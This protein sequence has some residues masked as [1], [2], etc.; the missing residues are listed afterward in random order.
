MLP[1]DVLDRWVAGTAT[2]EDKAL[3]AASTARSSVAA[4]L[5]QAVGG[6]ESYSW[7]GSDVVRERVFGVASTTPPAKTKYWSRW[8]IGAG[9]LASAVLVVLVA[10]KYNPLASNSDTHPEF[11]TYTTASGQRANVTLP[12]GS[13]A[14]LAPATTMRV[15]GVAGREIQL[16]G[17]AVF[18]V[19]H[20]KSG[21]FTVR[22]NGRTVRVLGTTFGVRTYD[23]LRVAVADGR[24]SIGSSVLSAGDVATVQGNTTVITQNA[25][26]TT[27]LAWTKG[28]LTFKDM[29]LRDVAHDI[30]RWFGV[31]LIIADPDLANYPVSATLGGNTPAQLAEILANGLDARAELRG[32]EIVISKHR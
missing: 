15:T 1:L 10:S 22:A 7:T 26:V 9:A 29:P 3:V 2:D 32:S 4:E 21:A 19:A 23:K 12:D 30:E 16:Q 25:D 13:V 24:V 27:M 20:N 28:E 8:V 5:L 31:R 18:V 17:E 14:T 6:D 11:R